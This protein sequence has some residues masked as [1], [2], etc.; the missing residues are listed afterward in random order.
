M[1]FVAF[2][3]PKTEYLIDALRSDFPKT[4]WLGCGISLSFV[5]GDVARAPVWIQ[6]I[7]LEWFHRMLQEPGRLGGRY[8][9]RNL[10]FVIRGLWAAW[11]GSACICLGTC[12]TVAGKPR[13]AKTK[14]KN[15]H[16]GD[17]GDAAAAA[18]A[19][20]ALRCSMCRLTFTSGN[21]LHKHLKEAHSG[22]HKK[23]R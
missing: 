16:A 22:T 2:G 5:T 1:V 10:P 13:R 14:G 9:R 3:S 8:L 11:R 4:W 17:G 21:A 20:A 23:K 15:K 18:G 7:G 12:T 19:G 6:R